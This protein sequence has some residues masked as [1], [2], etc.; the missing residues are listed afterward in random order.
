MR[1][2]YSDPLQEGGYLG[3]D[4]YTLKRATYSPNY[5]FDRTFQFDSVQGDTFVSEE[6][7]IAFLGTLSESINVYCRS[8]TSGGWNSLGTVTSGTVEYDVATYMTG[9]TFQVRLVDDTTSSDS[10]PDLWQIDGM[11]ITLEEFAPQ[12]YMPTS[13]SFF[14]VNTF[15]AHKSQDGEYAAVAHALR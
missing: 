2:T 9:D 11:W 6:L 1:W 5:R 7:S 3:V 15:Y 4:T 10:S 14:D 13:F 12:S 8:G